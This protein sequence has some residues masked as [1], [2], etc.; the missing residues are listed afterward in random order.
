MLSTSRVFPAL[1]CLTLGACASVTDERLSTLV[2]NGEEY[3]LRTRTL[4]G[5]NG[6]F[7]TT[8]AIVRGK[9]FVCRIDSPGDCEAAVRIGR[10]SSRFDSD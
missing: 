7:E 6:S 1:A 9:A 10:E 2:V 4:E 8:S 3:T 5:P